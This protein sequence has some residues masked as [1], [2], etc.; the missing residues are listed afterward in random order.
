MAGENVRNYSYSFSGTY[1]DTAVVRAFSYLIGSAKN[2]QGA[3]G[4]RE[5]HLPVSSSSNKLVKEKV[6]G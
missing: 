2:V 6:Y 4:S 5:T 3:T 1:F